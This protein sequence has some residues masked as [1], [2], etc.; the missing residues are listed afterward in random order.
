MFGASAARRRFMLRARISGR[1]RISALSGTKRMNVRATDR[2]TGSRLVGGKKLRRALVGRPCDLAGES[3][4]NG[5][6]TQSRLRPFPAGRTSRGNLRGT[7]ALLRR[8]VRSELINETSTPGTRW[9]AD[10]CAATSLL[11]DQWV[12]RS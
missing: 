5:Y 8:G 11:A 9:R 6:G 10:I 1:L 3:E 4:L 7:A 2:G 12:T